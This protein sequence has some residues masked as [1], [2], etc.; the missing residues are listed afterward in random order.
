V[1]LET[2]NKVDDLLAKLLLPGA[3]ADKSPESQADL[4]ESLWLLAVDLINEQE[5]DR[6]WQVTDI[7][8]Q[9]AHNLVS[10]RLLAEVIFRRGI[11][12]YRRGELHAALAAWQMAQ[13]HFEEVGQDEGVANCRCN[14]GSLYKDLGQTVEARNYLEEAL[15]T[16]DRLAYR[17]GKAACLTNLGLVLRVQGELETAA[18]YYQSALQLYR[19][20]ED[21][22]GEA[23][24]LGNLG[25]VYLALGQFQTSRMHQENALVINR[26]IGYRKGEASALGNI[27]SAYAEMGEYALAADYY[28]QA[29]VIDREL[30]N[31]LEVATDLLNLAQLYMEMGEL[32]RA[33]AYANEAQGLYQ[34]GGREQGT[35][36]AKAVTALIYR[37]LGNAPQAINQMQQ[38]LALAQKLGH[39]H[40]EATIWNNFSMLHKDRGTWREAA[41]CQAK[42]LELYQAVG[43]QDGQ[44]ASLLNLGMIANRLGRPEEGLRMLRLANQINREIGSR[45]GALLS[46]AQMALILRELG[47]PD[48]ALALQNEALTAAVRINNPDNIWRIYL[49]RASTLVELGDIAE[50][51]A[52]LR[53]AIQTIESLRGQLGY[54]RLQETFFGADKVSVYRR[55]VLLLVRQ[56]RQASEALMTAERARSRLFLDELATRPLHRTAIEAEAL[57]DR[58]SSLLDE[59]S[60]QQGQATAAGLNIAAEKAL[61]STRQKLEALWQDMERW[62]PAYVSL[63]R[64]D[65]FNYRGLQEAL[66]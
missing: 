53:R 66:Q 8:E 39:R 10:Q 30:D 57:F 40:Q 9:I 52:D 35:L 25:L 22:E 20:S 12:H 11:W 38:A 17:E 65:L 42:A 27:G 49:G 14:N 33:L 31:P 23:A 34:T 7:A 43:D 51:E 3:I 59:W 45:E 16:Y 19:E 58:E 6:A 44:A 63:R 61:T 36:E 64:A 4:A 15:A 28:S 13:T 32:A 5:W 21:Q 47:K 2:K 54:R 24:V 60:K 26:E 46:Q 56:R 29:L 48:E 55:L 37:S 18:S 50:A 1:N 62:A 41:V